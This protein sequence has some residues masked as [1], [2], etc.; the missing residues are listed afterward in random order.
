MQEHP[1]AGGRRA[2]WWQRTMAV[3]WQLATRT[4]P[5]RVTSPKLGATWAVLA[6][7]AGVSR[8]TL[9]DRLRWLRE[10]GLLVVLTTGSTARY[11]RGT[12]CGL[13]DDGL[14]NL[15]AEYI[16]TLPAEVLA[17]LDDAEL[18][19]VFPLDGGQTKYAGKG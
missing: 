6:E 4:G 8:S 15:A 12:M 14:G 5:D 2:D 17:A 13:A 19:Q 7:A 18:Q 1:D 3:V 9:A 16:L 11:R 10:C